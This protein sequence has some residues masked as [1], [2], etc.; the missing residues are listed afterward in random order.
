[1]VEF[2]CVKRNDSFNSHVF[3]CVCIMDKFKLFSGHE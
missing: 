1:M 2:S 3:V